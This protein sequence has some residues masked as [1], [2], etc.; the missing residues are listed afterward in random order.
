MIAQ[1]RRPGVVLQS[2]SRGLLLYCFSPANGAASTDVIP[3]GSS[4][5]LRFFDEAAQ[6]RLGYIYNCA[7]DNKYAYLFASRPYPSDVEQ[8]SLVLKYK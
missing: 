3:E 1:H 6:E 4:V 7:T 2:E 8:V 5:H